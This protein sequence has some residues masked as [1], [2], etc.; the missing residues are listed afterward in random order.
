MSSTDKILIFAVNDVYSLENFGR[1]AKFIAHTVAEQKPAAYFVTMAGDFL[2]PSMLSSIDKGRLKVQVMNE[3]G[4]THVSLGN[5]EF[6]LSVQVLLERLKEIKATVLNSNIRGIEDDVVPYDISTVKMFEGRVEFKLGWL[7]L[8][9]H[10]TR[11]MCVNIPK[12][13]EITPIENCVQGLLDD[14]KK[15]VDFN[16]LMTHQDVSFDR[17]TIK[18]TPCNLLLG[19]H[20]HN[21]FVEELKNVE[22][23]DTWLVKVG[24]NATICGCVGIEVNSDGHVEKVSVDQV[25]IHKKSGYPSIPAIDKMAQRGDALVK[26]VRS[27]VLWEGYLDGRGGRE[28][29]VSL[30]TFIL[31]KIRET[32]RGVDAAFFH[33][34]VVKAKREFAK[35]VTV[36]DILKDFK[37]GQLTNATVPGSVLVEMV[38]E[39]H[40]RGEGKHFLQAD[41]G[42]VIDSSHSVTTV[43]GKPV[44][45]DKLYHIVVPVE[46]CVEKEDN[47][48]VVNQTLLKYFSENPDKLLFDPEHQ[49]PNIC[50]SVVAALITPCWSKIFD[51]LTFDEIDRNHDGMLDEQEIM[52]VCGSADLISAIFSVGDRNGDGKIDR[53]EW[54]LQ[55]KNSEI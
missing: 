46:I 44:K 29:R 43:R 52:R 15:K 16:I 49:P 31:T 38:R 1:L 36:E 13:I 20:D 26:L 55:A 21:V 2:S 42:I 6:D 25:E 23:K 5:H 3:C 4:F 35:G 40:S 54:N 24:K 47:H 34:G 41:S 19:G 10:H 8:C 32:R 17:E 48:K 7:G 18:N 27:K 50:D 28:K 14:L 53:Q 33:G 12:K 39:S 45:V 51:G 30:Y 9:T 37:F 11:Q 22:G